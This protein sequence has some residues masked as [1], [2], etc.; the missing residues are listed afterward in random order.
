[1]LFVNLYL[2]QGNKVFCKTWAIP[3]GMTWPTWRTI[4]VHIDIDNKETFF[5]KTVDQNSLSLLHV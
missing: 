1:M 4:W 3:Q 2:L 5:L